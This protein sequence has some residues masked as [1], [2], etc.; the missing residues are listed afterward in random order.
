MSKFLEYV[1]SLKDKISDPLKKVTGVSSSTMENINKL[2]NQ[3]NELDKSFSKVSG[4]GVSRFNVAMGNLY[5]QGIQKVGSIIN[6]AAMGAIDGTI[7]REQDIIGLTTFL[8]DNA[9]KVYSAI[10]Y[11]AAVTPFGLDSLLSVNRGLIS[12]GMNA[13]KAR[14]DALNL[15]NAVAAVGGSDDVLSRMGANMQQIANTGKASAMDIKQFAYAGINIYSLLSKAT[16]KSVQQVQ[17]MDVSYSL[18]SKSLEA[19][20]QKGGL[21]YGASEKQSKTLG[22]MLSTLHDNFG[23]FMS[24]AGEFMKPFLKRGIEYLQKFIDKAPQI[25]SYLK[26]VINLIGSLFF[27]VIDAIRGVVNFFQSWYDKIKQGNPAIVILTAAIVAIIGNIILFQTVVLAIR[28]ALMLWAAAQWVINMAMLSNPIGLVIAGIIALAAIVGY[29]IYRY[30]GW[31]EAWKNLVAYLSNSWN[32]FKEAF[33]FVWL[34]VVDGFMSGIEF[35]QKGWYKFKSL[36]DEEGA[37]AGLAKLNDQANERAKQIAE[38]RGKAQ[39]YALMAAESWNKIGLKDSGKGVKEFVTDIK[40][41]LGLTPQP[42]TVNTV[43]NNEPNG[44]G[45]GKK[46]N[47]AVATGGTKNTVINIQIGKQIEQLTVV[48]NSIKEGA[49][50]I[51]DLIVDEMTRA[52]AMSQAIAE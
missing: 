30:T 8:G 6:Q 45:T 42:E 43:H 35:M 19:A 7:K 11:D 28:G 16:G 14:Q 22:G 51:R 15:A 32:G 36:W 20:A 25:L 37:N 10:E 40:G 3:V 23:K 52:L 49:E 33:N 26:P 13:D 17:E 29:I 1:L 4:G 38:S 46:S 12:T 44:K 47:E 21:Y 2:N 39:E 5:A 24:D 50:K 48:S 9:K 31:G 41:K 27:W 18:L 34:N